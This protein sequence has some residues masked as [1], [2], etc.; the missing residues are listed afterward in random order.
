MHLCRGNV[1]VAGRTSPYS[2]YSPDLASFTMGDSYNPKDARGFINL[3]GLPIEARAVL[4]S[5][6]SPRPGESTSNPTSHGG[7]E[8]NSPKNPLP[9]VGR[10]V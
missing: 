7:D 6:I 2:L 8:K 9:T 4:E 1:E 10:T 3:I 5:G